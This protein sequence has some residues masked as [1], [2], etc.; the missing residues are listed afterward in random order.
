MASPL[1]VTIDSTYADSGTDASVKLH[2]QHHDALHALYN[3][4]IAGPTVRTTA[5]TSVTVQDADVNNLIDCTSASPVT[6]TIPN[7]IVTPGAITVR[8]GGTGNVTM[9]AG[10]GVTLDKPGGRV[11]VTTQYGTMVAIVWGAVTHYTLS[12][13]E[14]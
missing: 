6:V 1:P 13:A 7:S 8:K 9:A 2:Q 12:G 10:A 11:T 3:T 14:V 4:Q 5:L